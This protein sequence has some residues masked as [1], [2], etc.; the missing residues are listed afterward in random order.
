MDW[1]TFG[2]TPLQQS[3][4]ICTW[5]LAMRL[6]RREEL[7]RAECKRAFESKLLDCALF[8]YLVAVPT[9]RVVRETVERGSDREGR[10][11]G[12]GASGMDERIN[13]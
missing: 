8:E 3:F 12:T 11:C 5:L 13:L 4:S 2:L 6:A 10:S 9:K 1:S 7:T